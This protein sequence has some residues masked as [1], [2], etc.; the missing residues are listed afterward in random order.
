MT[1][2]VLILGATGLFGGLLA[3]QLLAAGSFEVVCAGRDAAKLTTL[4]AAHGGRP[5]A[6]DRARRADVDQAL[7]TLRPFAVVDAAG[8][9]QD[10]GTDP[11]AFARAV[12]KSGA[13]YLDIADAAEFVAGIAG[14]DALAKEH[15]VAAMSG[16]SSTPA[17]S[18]AAVD[19]LIEGLAEIEVIETAILP[20]NRTPRGRS[21]MRAILRQVGQPVRV[22]RD[23][24]WHEARGWSLTKRYDVVVPGHRALRG[25]YASLVNTPDLVLFPDRYGARTVLFRAG[26]ELGLFHHGLRAARWLV[27]GRLLPTLAVLA[28]PAVRIASWFRHTGSDRGG[29]VVQVIGRTAEGR[30]EARAWHLIA[31]DGH[32]PK[33]PV[34]PVVVLLEKLRAGRIPAG[35]R[36][37]LGEVTLSELEEAMGAFGVVTR[38]HTHQL[39]SLFERVLGNEL[40]RLPH[41]IGALHRGYGRNIYA[42]RAQI[43]G[44][45]GWLAWLAARLAGFPPA[46]RDVPVKVTIDATPERE[47]WTRQFGTRC[48]R[49]V[50]TWDRR[51]GRAVERFGSL[52]FTL[53]L[54]RAGDELHYPVLSGRLLGVIPLPR[55][56]LPVSVTRE[57]VDAAGR[58]CFD[59]RVELWS[60]RRIAHY[61][62]VL[63][64]WP[65][66]RRKA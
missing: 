23:G 19:G 65:Q 28:D 62:G 4:C 33:I 35:A 57:H 47:V 66:A 29:M 39:P 9:F 2:T 17:L 24:E 51:T 61:R 11:Y 32:G 27:Q 55:L 7:A 52:A 22:M 3:R 18:A 30:R 10:Y 59:V 38:R 1:E 43:D 54:A 34:Q 6:I 16:A 64:P 49:S 26:L 14:L 53:G 63:E 46:S 31:A 44:P 50:L 25:R 5:V 37:C 13:H 8:P 58:F 48:F 20:G 36:P 21:V 15:G 12:I 60:G 45:D 42:G 56:V 41:A 40:D